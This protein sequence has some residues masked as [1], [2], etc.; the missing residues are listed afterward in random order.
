MP[1]ASVPGRLAQGQD[2]HAIDLGPLD[3]LQSRLPLDLE[4]FGGRVRVDQSEGELGV[5]GLVCPHLLGPLETSAEGER[6]LV[7][8][9]HGYRFSRE[10][11]RSCAGRKYRIANPARW[12]V[13]SQPNGKHVRL[14]AAER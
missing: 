7:C 6:I 2:T 12:V 1:T 4:A 10:S 8:P 9:W 11:Q 13:E 3:A 14:V 5:H